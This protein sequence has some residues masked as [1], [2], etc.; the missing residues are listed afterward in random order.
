LARAHSTS[1]AALT[2]LLVCIGLFNSLLSDLYIPALRLLA[3]DLGTTPLRAQQT[4]SLFFLACAFMSL[5]HGAIADAWGRKPT[6]LVALAVLCLSSLACVAAS[7]IEPL[8]V[9][10]TLQGLAAGSGVV[11]SRA[12]VLD[13][14]QGLAAQRM[15]GRITL[16]QT[17]APVLMP[18]VGGWIA[19]A[20]GWRAVFAFIAV[21][22]AAMGMAVWRWLPETLPPA[23]RRPLHPVSLW[24]AYAEVLG[25][26]SFLRLA[27][28]HV[29]N[30]VSLIL[31]VVAAPALVIGLLG[32]DETAFWL[33]YVPMM[34]GMVAGF[35]LF[36]RI[37]RHA[38][39]HMPLRLAYAILGVGVA[40]SLILS[41]M[42]P[43][44]LHNLVPLFVQAF[45]VAL[46]MPALIGMALDPFGERAGVASSCHSFLQ[47]GA[48]AAVAGL[49]APLVWGSMWTMA[50][51]SACLTATGALSLWWER[52][53]RISAESREN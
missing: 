40:S 32:R 49:L 13:I 31:Y 6:V 45:G 28:A 21:V 29:A 52:S 38:S 46:A 43:P 42:L 37:A 33:V 12:I 20:F 51:G 8:L 10:R 17:V 24:H 19:L 7:R 4:I 14:H 44:G 22:V 35:V 18:I 11:I 50:L 16:V 15:L 53:A 2:A 26:R 3:N 25:S 36:P 23:R 47:F 41:R 34:S 9:L 5:W 39:V 1:P 48:T 30:W 27:V